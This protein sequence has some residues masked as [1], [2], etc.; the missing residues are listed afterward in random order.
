MEPPSFVRDKGEAGL[1]RQLGVRLVI[2]ADDEDY[3]G[4][5]CW[6]GSF[7]NLLSGAPLHPRKHSPVNFLPLS[8]LL[9]GEITFSRRVSEEAILP[10]A[11][12]AF[13][14]GIVGGIRIKGFRMVFGN[15]LK[16]V[17][18]DFRRDSKKLVHTDI[19]DFRNIAILSVP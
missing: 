11:N 2:V 19:A 6:T 10:L 18:D 4:E 17:E 12:P 8:Q 13:P 5:V 9:A 15:S 14:K 3:V 7:T 1:I 16:S